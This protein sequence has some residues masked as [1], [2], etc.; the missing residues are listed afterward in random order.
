[1]QL[2]DVEKARYEMEAAEYNE[3]IKHPPLADHI[4]E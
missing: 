1:M 3:K 4:F 2:S